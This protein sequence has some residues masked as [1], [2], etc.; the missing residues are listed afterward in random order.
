MFNHT[1]EVTSIDYI[2]D[3]T[4]YATAS[5][6]AGASS[7]INI[8]DAL[9]NNPIGSISVSSKTPKVVKFTPDGL[10]IGVGFTDGTVN[11]YSSAP[12][13]PIS[14]YTYSFSST[15]NDIHF[16]KLSTKL[17]VCYSNGY[18]IVTGYATATPS[19]SGY[20]NMASSL[21]KCRFSDN[22]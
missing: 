22:D 10:Y 2:N 16:N 21:S 7:K 15:L 12:P 8:Y 4:L 9:T 19:T 14:A 17:I 5:V 1:N 13:F 20:N 18:K 11:L 6:P 3:N